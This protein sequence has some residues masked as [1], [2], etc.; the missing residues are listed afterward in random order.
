V[1]ATTLAIV[2]AIACS[3]PSAHAD[4]LEDE[5]LAPAVIASYQ[6]SLI[7]NTLRAWKLSFDP[8]PDGKIIEQV[9]VA[10]YD[11]I[12]S[13]DP[14]PKFLNVLHKITEEDIVTQELLF[15]KGDKWSSEFTNES[16]R[17]IRSNLLVSVAEVVPVRGSSSDKVIAVVIVKDIWSLRLE[18]DFSLVGANLELLEA[19][20]SEQNFLG[21]NKR[22]GANFRYDPATLTLGQ[23]FDDPRILGS[24]IAL[25][26]SVAVI[27]N[28]GSGKA[29]GGYGGLSVGLP[30]YSLASDWAWSASISHRQDVFRLFSGGQVAEVSVSTGET[31]PYVVDRRRSDFNLSATRSYGRLLK[32]NWSFGWSGTIR[33]YGLPDPAIKVVTPESIQAFSDAFLPRTESFG[34]LFTGVRFFRTDFKQLVDVE[35]YALTEDYRFGPDFSATVAFANPVF[36]FNSTFVLPSIS[37]DYNWF[38]GDNI[39][40]AGA[41]ASLRYQPQAPPSSAWV[42]QIVSFGA[43]HVSPRIGGFKFFTG[44]RFTRRSNDMDRG[45]TFIGGESVLRGFPSNYFSGTQAWSANIEARTTPTIIRTVHAGAAFFVDMGDAA[46][47]FAD[48]GLNA[49]VGA[50]IRLLFP[51]FNRGVLRLDFAFPLQAL[52]AGEEASY[53]TAKFGQAF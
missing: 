7:Q 40:S 27:W 41:D 22:I 8:N 5:E 49:S 20:L 26:E 18:W 28:K 10:R 13:S 2:I 24:R 37:A 9:R 51:Q 45:Q 11:V 14:F 35:T 46:N 6:D 52:P 21:R 34:T 53:I 1:K 48:L 39:L 15:K 42:N 32:A 29:E 12:S 25:T 43:K 17:N 47:S 19:D 3:A 50:G 4:E 44:G 16:E 23:R 31:V 30:L 33:N 38:I 36:G